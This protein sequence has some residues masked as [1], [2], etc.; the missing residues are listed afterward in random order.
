[1]FK[2]VHKK[3]FF[4]FFLGMGI[5]IAISLLPNFPEKSFIFSGDITTPI[6][7][8]ESFLSS[9]WEN[10]GRGFLWYGFFWLTESLSLSQGL[11]LSLYLMLFFLFS[12]GSF[13]W[14]A[15]KF[16]PFVPPF[17]LFAFSFLYAFNIFVGIL[18]VS[19]KLFSALGLLYSIL[20]FLVGGYWSFFQKPTIERALFFIFLFFIAGTAFVFP[21]VAVAMGVFFCIFTAILWVFSERAYTWKFLIAL[22]SL[23]GGV[24]LINAYAFSSLFIRFFY[25]EGV[26]LPESRMEILGYTQNISYSIID[27]FRLME[28]YF[29]FS[30]NLFL[31]LVSFFPLVWI[32][33]GWIT[34][35]KS[36]EKRIFWLFLALFL[37]CSFLYTGLSGKWGFLYQQIFVLSERNI[38]LDGKIFS[39]FIPF[40]GIFL[41]LIVSQ[42]QR[43]SHKIFALSALTLSLLAFPFFLSL[44]EGK[45]EEMSQEKEDKQ[46]IS[47]LQEDYFSL[48]RYNKDALEGSIAIFPYKE[49]ESFLDDS[50]TFEK[51]ILS[52]LLQ[53]E[54]I[55]S[56]DSYF[57]N[58]SH[59]KA[60]SQ[61]IENPQWMPILLGMAQTRYVL[62]NASSSEEDTLKKEFLISEQFLEKVMETETFS[63]YRIADHLVF[64]LFFIPEKSFA[65]TENPS[66]IL[67][68]KDTITKDRILEVVHE[69]SFG[70][71]T[72]FVDG[73]YSGKDLV[74]ARP[75]HSLWEANFFQENETKKTLLHIRSLG[76]L[77]GWELPQFSQEARIEIVFL[78]MKFFSTGLYVTGITMLCGMMVTGGI[79]LKKKLYAK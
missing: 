69:K 16:F 27:A 51:N 23:W 9:L 31:I 35:K 14:L 44:Y 37:C 33:F 71:Y 34:Q 53:R 32:I 36:G 4:W 57:G 10:E 60:F 11:A 21:L 54:I 73:T 67:A 79:Y 5:L 12:Y 26:S 52:P 17:V 13:W 42:F 59:T 48:W 18:F 41:G 20:P 28:S 56:Q 68:L 29:L 39:L 47:T 55:S 15:R 8:K 24:L 6:F 64:P 45:D 46:S 70:K 74:F 50:A 3:Y 7:G 65:L 2:N 30:G 19:G 72:L 77:N 63:F 62:W 43:A 76:L 38:F 78:P 66:S 25:G 61:S 1:M 40:L 49:D 58:W 22:F 75:F